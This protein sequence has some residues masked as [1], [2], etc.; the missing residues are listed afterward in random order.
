MKTALIAAAMIACVG[1]G[2]QAAEAIV[3]GGFETGAIS[4]WFN[5]NNFG[6]IGGVPWS[7]TTTDANTGSWSATNVGNIE[8]R[9]NF[10]GVATNDI[11]SASLWLK[12]PVGG[13]LPA[14]VTF[15]Y[16]DLTDTNFV[17]NTTTGDWEFFD[18]SANLL[19]GKMLTGFS[20]YGYT[21]GTVN[22]TS[23][24]DV[25]I[26]FNAVPEPATWAL[27]IGGFVMVGSA[28]RRGVSRRGTVA[29]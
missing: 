23:L 11:T 20:L 21:L 10:A 1:S 27:M 9:Q 17:I 19:A 6:G 29:V 25:S 7:A 14:Y 5:D 28:M 4:P 18:M 15:F 2:V 26:S 12:H 24:D 3:N 13:S 22:V 16:S 8:I